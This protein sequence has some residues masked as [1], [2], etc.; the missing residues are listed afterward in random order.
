MKLLASFVAVA[1]FYAICVFVS[2]EI[3][4]LLWAEA[5]RLFFSMG[6]LVVF[7]MTYTCPAWGAKT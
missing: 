6:S 7:G 4:P 5:G 3:N 1:V 2:L